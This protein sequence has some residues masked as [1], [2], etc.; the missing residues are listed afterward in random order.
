MERFLPRIWVFV[1]AFSLGISVSASWRIYTSPAIPEPVVGPLA[2]WS[3]GT[4]TPKADTASE[5]P[6]LLEGSHNCGAS[7][8]GQ[9]YYYDDGGW[10]RPKC[11]RFKSSS[12]ATREFLNRLSGATIDDRSL[13]MDGNGNQI[14]EEILITA[15]QI[16]KIRKKGRLLCEVEASSLYHLNWFEKQR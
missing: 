13:V 1:V 5:G 10:V 8:D 11:R 3:A 2:W 9:V 6:K 16:A 4:E 7:A 12:V 15:P 14:G